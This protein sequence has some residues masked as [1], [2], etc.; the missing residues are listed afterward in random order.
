MSAARVLR[1]HQ[2]QRS[3]S[4][5]AVARWVPVQSAAASRSRPVVRCSQQAISVQPVEAEE[6][7]ERQYNSSMQAA[8]GW[9]GNPFEYHPKVSCMRMPPFLDINPLLD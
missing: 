4:H 2:P 8:M 7:Q 9:S 6:E 1:H 5:R 3:F